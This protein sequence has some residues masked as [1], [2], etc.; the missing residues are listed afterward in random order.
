MSD[1]A[2]GL[3]EGLADP[4]H[5]SQ[6]LFRGVLEA[7]SHPGRIVSLRD[8]PAAAGPLSRAATAFILGAVH[9]I[10]EWY[11]RDGKESV[12]EIAEVHSA[13]AMAA[14]RGYHT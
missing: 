4:S 13:Y 3:A 1:I 12:D 14:L 10:A 11:G 2:Q 5:D 6:R 7:F 9:N 8:T